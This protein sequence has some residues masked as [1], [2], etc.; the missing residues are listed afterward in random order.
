M[1]A[2]LVTVITPTYNHEQYI[3]P[4]IESVLS[5]SYPHWEQ[6]IIDD[7]S[8]DKT[9]DV[10]RS[11]NDARIRYL[12]QENLGIFRLAETYN[13]ALA[14]ARGELIAT[15]EGDDFWPSDKLETLV[16]AFVD[17]QVVLAYGITRLVTPSGKPTKFTIPSYW[18]EKQYTRSALF[19]D[20]VG[21]GGRLMAR[22]DVGTFTYPP[23][24]VVRASA[25][26][27]IGG[28]QGNPRFPCTDYPTFLEL[29]VC[30]RFFF[31][32]RVMGYWR[33]RL[34]SGTYTRDDWA[35]EREQRQLVLRFL[36][37][38]SDKLGL[39]E[40]ERSAIEE[41]F[42]IIRAKIWFF[43]GRQ[44]LL[45]RRWAEARR[46]FS[47][48]LAAKTPRA[49]LRASLGY[50]AGWLHQDLEGLLRVFGRGGDFRELF[51]LDER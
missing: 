33:Q 29:T 32:P 44:L 43:R 25:L 28:F 5:Q 14:A 4:C 7:G 45:L 50:L 16:P 20:P 8:T 2:P 40:H 23:S 12:R 18:F 49:R 11:Y 6:V 36:N 22:A 3:R 46:F 21:S 13:R 30:G 51:G 34:R 24:V 48:G 19:N 38:H 26:K 42:D 17:E 47:V 37:K 1:S 31:I 9:P 41:S 39:D 35:T 10:I 15:L 27:A